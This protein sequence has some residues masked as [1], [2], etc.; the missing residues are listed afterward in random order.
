MEFYSREIRAFHYWIQGYQNFY[1][2]IVEA[3]FRHVGYTV[4]ELKQ[5]LFRAT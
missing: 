1:E 2:P 3:Y 5:A 4:A